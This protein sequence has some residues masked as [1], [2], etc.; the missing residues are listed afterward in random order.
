[1]APDSFEIDEKIINIRLE[2]RDIEWEAVYWM[3]LAQDVD[4]WFL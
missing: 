1:M 3:H 2:L 4:Q